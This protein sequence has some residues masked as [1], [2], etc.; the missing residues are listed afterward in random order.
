MESTSAGATQGHEQEHKFPVTIVYNGAEK[1][2]PVTR[3]ELIKA[4]LARAILLF[5]VTQ[6]PHMLSLFTED[7]TEL[8]DNTTVGQDG[9]TKESVVYLRQSKVKG[10]AFGW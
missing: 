6:Q 3:D 7:G 8:N 4:I 2:E 9:L 1:H 5:H 10:G